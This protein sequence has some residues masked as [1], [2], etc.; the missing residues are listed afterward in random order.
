MDQAHEQIARLGAVQG[1]VEQR[2]LP[3]KHSPLQRLFADVMPRAGLC[4]VS[5]G[6]PVFTNC[7]A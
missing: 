5:P 3:V 1:L 6:G 4:R 7:R 2:I